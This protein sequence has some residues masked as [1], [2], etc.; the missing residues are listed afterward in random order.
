MIFSLSSK[1][2]TLGL[3]AQRLNIKPPRLVKDL[4]R[5]FLNYLVKKN[6]RVQGLEDWSNPLI[7]RQEDAVKKVYG[8][9]SDNDRIFPSI[10][11]PLNVPHQFQ[12]PIANALKTKAGLR[13][14]LVTDS[15]DVGGM[16]EVVVFLTRGL[17]RFGV[18]TAVL[19]ASANG[20]SDGIPTGRLAQQ[21]VES[22]IETVELAGAAGIRWLESWRPDVISA[23]C[24][25]AWVLEAAIRLSIPYVDTLHGQMQL[26]EFEK[27]HAK[28][29]KRA[30]GLA[31]I[32]AVGDMICR[33]YL[34]LNP[35]FSPERIITIPNGVD[36]ERRPPVNRD[37]ARARW[38]VRDEYVFVSLGRHCLQKNTYGLVAGF[39][40]VAALHPEAHLVIAGRVDDVTY[41]AQVQ[42]FRNSLACR[43]RIHLRDHFS[44]PAELL[45]LADGFVLNSFFEAG[46]LVSMEALH[47]GVPVVISDVGE[48]RVQVGNGGKRGHLVPN[49]IGDPLRVN[50]E[51]IREA[52]YV[53]QINREALVEAMSSLIVN[54]FSF[55]DARERLMIESSTRFHPDVCLRSHAEV[56][57]A[58]ANRDLVRQQPI[59]HD[60]LL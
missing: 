26:Y 28:E 52:R 29:A 42:R 17:P 18:D 16:D 20:T 11:E 36:H 12:P 5:S 34:D 54:R 33:Q 47:A 9:N 2:T 58:A 53:N 22:G 23:H 37:W 30:C 46:P 3:T 59:T 55:L 35:T 4:L 8:L 15:L 60:K 49:P 27:D 32:V 39:A 45:A 41:F 25:P 13:C 14:L 21:L 6:T 24:A 56:L 1:L 31:G 57:T 50:W 40:E 43:N 48:A 7:V 44:D 51:T 19:H 10:V 38:G